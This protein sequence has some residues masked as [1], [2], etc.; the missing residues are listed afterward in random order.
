MRVNPVELKAHLMAMPVAIC[1]AAP[2]AALAQSYPVKPVRQIVS[3]GPGGPSDTQTRA[4]GQALNAVF[5]QPF[6]AE[7][8]AGA[9]GAIALEA[10][11][12]SP[13]DGH[14]LC[15][16]D[17]TSTVFNP[18]MR[19]QMPINV[20]T[21]IVPVMHTGFFVS[22]LAVS[23]SLGVSTVRELLDAARAKP[24]AI[25]WGTAGSSSSSGLYAEWIRSARGANFLSVP[26]KSNPAALQALVAGQVMATVF[27]VGA[28]APLVRSGKLKALAVTSDK[29]A[30]E[31]PDV[32][33]F[34]EA[35]LDINSKNWLGIFAPAAVPRDV[36]ARINTEI[37]KLFTDPAFQAKYL[38]GLGLEV[39]GPAGRSA[40]EFA[41]FLQAD[42]E[43]ARE[44]L[45]MAGIKPE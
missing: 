27:A 24:G 5:G 38:V 10:C 26:Y 28:V 32:P 12:K 15:H 25:P 7:N 37:G 30:P 31:L 20:A 41:R 23:P 9:N 8:R 11:A 3:G 35:G 18:L 34:D 2:C 16:L 45:K 1:L 33:T 36:I 19:Q 40:D 22:A 21:D 42:R 39:S 4:I 43:R 13:A 29:R 14:T 6:I 44:L 17:G